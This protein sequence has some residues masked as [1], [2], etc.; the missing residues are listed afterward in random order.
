MYSDNDLKQ[1]VNKATS[2]AKWLIEQRGKKRR[3]AYIIASKK[4]KLPS[5]DIVR[6]EYQKVK[7][8]QESLF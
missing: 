3:I 8:R 5:Y 4:Y 2:L 1:A 7:I 6:Q